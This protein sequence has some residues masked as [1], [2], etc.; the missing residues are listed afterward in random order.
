MKNIFILLFLFLKLNSF[1]Q[2]NVEVYSLL[3]EISLVKHSREIVNTN[4][5]KILLSYDWKAAEILSE[6][7]LDSNKTKVY[8]DCLERYLTIGEIA[9]II[10]DRIDGM[11]YYRLT[12]LQNCLME[13]CQG[14][15]NIIEYYLPYIHETSLSDFKERYLLWIKS[16][17]YVKSR[18]LFTDK[19]KKQL[20][21]I[22]REKLKAFKN[23]I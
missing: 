9:I 18:H 13:F 19:S 17:E 1:S 21:R 3:K 10:A 4:A 8:S 6:Y 11:N 2:T 12:L 22:Q 7:F 16:E 14:N 15:A 5:G 20:K 23:N